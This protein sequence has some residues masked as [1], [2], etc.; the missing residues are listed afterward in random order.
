M[1]KDKVTLKDATKVL[2]QAANH[3]IN[4]FD[5]LDKNNIAQLVESFRYLKSA[6][7][8]IEQLLKSLNLLQ[9]EL[10]S[11]I[12]P[13]AME[14]VQLD[15]VKSKGYTYSLSVRTFASI[16]L[17]KQDKGYAWLKEVGGDA[18]IK[19]TVNAKTLSSF[20]VGY[21][22]EH[23]KKPPEDAVSLHQKKYISIRKSP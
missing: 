23:G 14:N 20:I 8:A 18:I 13:T 1:S 16:P 9:E 3:T 11:D 12:I 22:E 19:P 7:D 6:T 15:S 17:D 21:I 5:E 4:Y 10:S 2:A